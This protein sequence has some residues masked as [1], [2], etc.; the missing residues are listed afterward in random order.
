[1]AQPPCQVTSNQR[2]P[3]PGQ[4]C[5]NATLARAKRLHQMS[6]AQPWFFIL[7]SRH[8]CSRN[9]IVVVVVVVVGGGVLSL[10]LLLLHPTL[11]AGAARFYARSAPFPFPPSSFLFP[12]SG[13]PSPPAGGPPDSRQLSPPAGVMPDSHQPSPPVTIPPDSRQ[14]SP[15]GNRQPS[16]TVGVPP[17][18]RQPSPP[19]VSRPAG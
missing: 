2:A 14:P 12:N 9:Q 17:D 3:T 6:S 16:P 7:F 10:L 19:R 5:K 4:Q 13:R 11:Q 18:I 1:M 15:P 8:G